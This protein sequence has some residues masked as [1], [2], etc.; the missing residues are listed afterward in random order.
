MVNSMSKVV[1]CSSGLVEDE[2]HFVADLQ[3][4]TL[5]LNV[6]TA[7]ADLQV[8]TLYLKICNS[9]ENVSTRIL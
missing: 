3:V 2:K 4:Q 7:V 1:L 8:Q 9:S 6:F 5:Y